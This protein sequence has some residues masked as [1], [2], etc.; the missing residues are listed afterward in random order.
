MKRISFLAAV[1]M[2]S[3]ASHAQINVGIKG[4]LNFSD[5]LRKDAGKSALDTKM[6]AELH[7]GFIADVKIWQNFYLQPQLLY[8]RKGSTHKSSTVADT[9]VKM[10]YVELPLNMVYKMDM[11]FGKVFVGAGPVISYGFGGELVQNGQSKKLYSDIKNFKREDI[12]A[13]VLAGIEL[14]NGLFA[15]VNYQRGFTD[16]YKTDAVNIKNRSVAV[17]VGYY[18]N[19]KKNLLRK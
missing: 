18:L 19:Y 5:Q 13:N 15:S 4:G 17:S 11:L 14:N 3:L 8:S 7:A 1:V 12:S 6:H 9:K 10:N 2:C 16:I